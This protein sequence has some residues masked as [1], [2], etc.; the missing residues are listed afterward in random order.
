MGVIYFSEPAPTASGI[1]EERA[2]LRDCG[3]WAIMVGEPAPTASG[4]IALFGLA[5]S[6][7]I[8]VLTIGF[9]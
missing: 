7:S 9:K 5:H 3:F 4:A 2:G 6:I 8:A 1:Q